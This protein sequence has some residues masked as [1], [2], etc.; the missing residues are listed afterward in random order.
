MKLSKVACLT[1]SL[2]LYMGIQTHAETEAII[3]SPAVLENSMMSATISD[4]HGFFEGL[5][6]VAVNISPMMNG[7]ILKN[8]AGAQFG[9]PQLDAIAH[10]KGIAV[11]MVDP[12]NI[13]AV[14][15]LNDSHIATYTNKL[16]AL[17]LQSRQSG[18]VL[19]IG[20]TAK[21][22]EGG[23]GYIS[24]VKTELL[25][26]RSPALKVSFSPT[27]LID[28]NS[29]KIEAT[30]KTITEGMNSAM[31]TTQTN[32]MT[33]SAASISNIVESEFRIVLSLAKQIKSAEIKLMPKNGSL[34]INKTIEPV[35][36]SALDKLFNAPIT[37]KWNPKVQ[38]GGL[39]PGTFK[40][41]FWIK[42]PKAVSAFIEAEADKL[43]AEMKFDA[44]AIKPSLKLIQN[45]MDIYAGTG[46]ENIMFGGKN[47]MC[48]AYIMEVNDEAAALN[49]LRK[50]ESNMK[51]SGITD[52]YSN[53][54][55]SMS[56]DL[57]ENV[58]EYKG[59]KIHKITTSM[60]MSNLP[61][62]QKQMA[63]MSSF[64][65]MQ[66][67][68]AI[69]DGVLAYTFNDIKIDDLIDKQKTTSIVTAPLHARE[70]LPSGGIY[71]IDIDIGSYVGF[72]AEMMPETHGIMPDFKQISETL[73]G[74]ENITKA[75]YCNNGRF[76]DTLVIPGSLLARVG[77]MIMMKAAT[78]T[79]PSSK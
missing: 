56:F 11:V 43:I 14:V 62:E 40:I 77:Q 13:F 21:Q 41:D 66:S 54:G 74:A 67:E 10:G 30:L 61:Q 45:S 6:S 12:S 18:D 75:G 5:G 20:Q 7:M 76:M 71:Y 48:G 69:F 32:S 37:T 33:E 59:I 29:Q 39:G 23:I 4:L 47:V 79:S 25:N 36:G 42:N 60:D 68:A 53:M 58:R 63:G 49:L 55:M 51:D 28:K 9:D 65:N 27:D 35:S 72:I 15:E 24:A 19:V 46:C 26:K 50:A 73:K 2:S 34:S 70:T 17:G 16:S 1:L 57:I 38:A 22:V 52:F 31:Q 78:A 44:A 3:E 64:T 8:M